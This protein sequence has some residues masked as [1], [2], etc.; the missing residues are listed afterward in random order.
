MGLRGLELR[1]GGIS[2]GGKDNRKCRETGL[3]L[4]SI[5]GQC[6]KLGK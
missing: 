6:G 1:T 4:E 2:G 5:R 3:E